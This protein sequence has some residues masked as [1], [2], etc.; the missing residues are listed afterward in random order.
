MNKEVYKPIPEYEN[1]GI[2]DYGE[3]KNLKHNRLKTTTISKRGQEVVV[4]C[5][6]G[7]PKTFN[8]RSLVNLTWKGI[9]IRKNASTSHCKKIRCEETGQT[10]N[11]HKEC[12][13]E[14][15]LPYSDFMET[16]KKKDEYRGYHFTRLD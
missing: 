5:K 1:Y 2:T 12:C 8:V 15:N 6:D 9:P 13:K 4:L 3:I 14:L 7:L 11:S 16:V 10:F